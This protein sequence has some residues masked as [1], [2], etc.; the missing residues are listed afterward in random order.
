M[1]AWYS[2]VSGPY[3]ARAQRE[4]RAALRAYTVRAESPQLIRR[5][6]TAAE[7]LKDSTLAITAS[8]GAHEVMAAVEVDEGAV[9]ELI[10]QMPPCFPLEPAEVRCEY[11]VC[12]CS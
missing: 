4:A 9:V 8:A 1:R 12:Y 10:V 7:A 5:E 11:C 2:S 6:V 3:N